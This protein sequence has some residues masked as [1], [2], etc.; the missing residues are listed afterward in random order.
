MTPVLR[1]LALILP[2]T[3][4][5]LPGQALELP[6][7]LTPAG[8]GRVVEVIDGDTLALADG[9]EVRLVGIQAP[10]LPLGRPDFPTWPL[11]P[12]AKKVLEELVLHREIAL[13]IGGRDRDRHGRV[14]AHLYR[15]SDG[16]WIQG[17]MVS[18]GLARVYT[19]ADNRAMAAALFEREGR[20][21]AARRG[22]WALG[23]YKMLESEAAGRALDRFALIEGTVLAADEVGG[24][25]YLNF[26]SDWKR[27][28]TAVI[29]AEGLR[30]FRSDGIDI[31]AYE[32]RRIR[33]RGWVEY[34]NGPMIE[35]THPEQIEEVLE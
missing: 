25:A 22:I 23:Y 10:K 14:L 21:R 5:A 30:V 24:S 26:G 33:V 9:R 17:E 6:A 18:R 32:G 11:A 20:A 2:L 15:R 7:E 1:F 19:F 27:D 13:G 16:L 4:T 12:E 34:W 31:V 29:R 8:S 35:V 28:F 3:A